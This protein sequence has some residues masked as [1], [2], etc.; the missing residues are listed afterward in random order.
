MINIESEEFIWMLFVLQTEVQNLQFIAHFCRAKYVTRGTVSLC[1]SKMREFSHKSNAN[2]EAIGRNYLSVTTAGMCAPD[3]TYIALIA[4]VHVTIVK[5]DAY[6][7]EDDTEGWPSHM[8]SLVTIT[9]FYR[10]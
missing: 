8:S 9:R 2:N 7:N 5:P 3:G 10:K 4:C 6:A 1:L